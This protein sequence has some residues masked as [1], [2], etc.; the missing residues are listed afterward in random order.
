MRESIEDIAVA[1]IG[2]AIAIGFWY[3]S[4]NLCAWMA[5]L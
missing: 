5:T 1:V 2:L 4:I 3:G